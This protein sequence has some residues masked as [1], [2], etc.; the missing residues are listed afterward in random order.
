VNANPDDAPFE[1]VTVLL[2]PASSAALRNA[3]AITGDSLTDTINRAIQSY[4]LLASQVDDGAKVIVR[5]G[6]R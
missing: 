3:A 5:G 6:A 2:T 4:A 1:Q